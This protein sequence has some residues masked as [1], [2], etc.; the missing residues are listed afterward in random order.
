M[1][2]ER[3]LKAKQ[4]GCRVFGPVVAVMGKGFCPFLKSQGRLQ[5]IRK[6][7]T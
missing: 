7:E 1:A 2:E 6:G 4:L 5:H 3:S